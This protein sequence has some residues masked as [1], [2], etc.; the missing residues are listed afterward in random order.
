[1]IG[2]PNIPLLIMNRGTPAALPDE[3]GHQQGVDVGD[4]VDHHDDA[5]AFGHPVQALPP[6]AEE[7][8]AERIDEHDAGPDPES[9]LGPMQTTHACDCPWPRS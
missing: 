6:D 5:A 2:L 3:P 1:M 7:Q 8:P 4:V 9:G